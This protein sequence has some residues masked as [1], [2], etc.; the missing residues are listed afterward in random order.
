MVAGV[1]SLSDESDHTLY[2]LYL[3]ARRGLGS[4]SRMSLG[5]GK[6]LLLVKVE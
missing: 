6:W 2:V 3:S 5:Y 4:C 1:Y